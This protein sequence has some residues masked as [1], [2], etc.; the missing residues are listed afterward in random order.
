ME[1]KVRLQKYL[2]ERGLSSRREA[3]SWIEDGI[4]RVNGKVAVLGT[5]VDPD[6]DH[7]TVAG[8]K[9]K[10]ASPQ[11]VIKKVVLAV[12]KP[13]GIL[14]S[15]ADPHHAQTIF[16]IL[17]GKYK[18]HRLFCVGRLDKES[19]GLLILTNDGE[20]SNRLTHPKYGVI[21][22]YQVTLNKPFDPKIAPLLIKGITD[23]GEHLCADKVIPATSGLNAEKRLEV[24]LKQGKNREIR[25]LFQAFAYR[26]HRLKRIQIGQFKLKQ[27]AKEGIKDL[28][29]KEIELLLG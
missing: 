3:E 9:L 12:N 20:L 21:K 14:C 22:R 23:E 16:D 2:A 29:K 4:V 7:V 13:R 5:K 25:R 27:I 1:N 26:V 8:K 24:H 10:P 11:N 18:R 17:P 28:S 15:N 19:E 6:K